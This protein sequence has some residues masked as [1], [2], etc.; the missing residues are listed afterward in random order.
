DPGDPR[1]PVG[2]ERVVE[3]TGEATDRATDTHTVG[4][5][6]D[7]DRRPIGDDEQT[8]HAGGANWTSRRPDGQCP[9]VGSTCG[10]LGRSPRR[11]CRANREPRSRP[12]VRLI[13]ARK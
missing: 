5:A 13:A 7:L 3:R 8:R 1:P 4:V 2:A 6:G 9:V 11:T 10:T 12:A